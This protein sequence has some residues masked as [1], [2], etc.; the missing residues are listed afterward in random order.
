MGSVHQEALKQ[1]AWAHQRHLTKH[2]ESESWKTIISLPPRYKYKEWYKS[3]SESN[4]SGFL[5]HWN[6]NWYSKSPNQT[7]ETSTNREQTAFSESTTTITPTTTPHL[8]S[9]IFTT[10]SEPNHHTMRSTTES[11]SI[12]QANTQPMNTS[13]SPI[14]FQRTA[15][16]TMETL[17]NA[18]SRGISSTGS[19]TTT[20]M[21][22]SMTLTSSHANNDSIATTVSNTQDDVEQTSDSNIS[23]YWTAGALTGTRKSEPTTS[24]SVIKHTEFSESTTTRIA[25]TTT[26]TVSSYYIPWCVLWNITHHWDDNTTAWVI[27][28][29]SSLHHIKWIN[30]NYGWPYNSRHEFI[31]LH[32]KLRT[33]PPHNQK[34][35]WDLLHHASHYNNQ[36]TLPSRQ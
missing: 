10:S 33:K 9:S 24:R 5:D 3:N 17:T 29:Y 26:T 23:I 30:N 14:N 13:V 15:T 27:R 6:I 25:P 19:A 1:L 36:W 18:T 7:T 4:I 21:D 35:N 12:S 32:I 11:Y 20:S 22:T 16:Q 2:T 8:S 34:Y 31:H 28:P